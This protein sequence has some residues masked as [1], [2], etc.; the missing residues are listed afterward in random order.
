MI[1]IGKG[2]TYYTSAMDYPISNVNLS[3]I[4][5]GMQ[6]RDEEHVHGPV[7]K[8]EHVFQFIF[9]GK[10]KLL[11]GENAYD[12]NEGDLFYLPKNKIVK[13]FS[14]KSSPYTYYWIGFDGASA[15]QIISRIGISEEN[16]VKRININEL[17][18]L[19]ES[20]KEDILKGSLL[21]YIE[22]NATMLKIFATLLSHEEEA[23]KTIK[24]VSID[25][26]DKALYFIKTNFGKDINVTEISQAV[27]LKRNYFCGLFKKQTGLSPVDYLMQYRI[28]QAKLMLASGMHVTETATNCGFNSPS[29]FGAQFKRLT[30]KTP[31]NYRKSALSIKN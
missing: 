30:G 4:N 6:G 5:F 13:Y 7:I 19:F 23:T 11:I 17:I 14:D 3:L 9:F 22:A 1:V 24:N 28:E 20:M 18:P 16:P 27:G 25:Y 10:G 26:V 29:N 12:L 21:G 31:L 8:T 15:R 2:L